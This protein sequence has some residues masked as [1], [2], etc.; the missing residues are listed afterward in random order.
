M[1]VVTVAVVMA[2]M[3]ALSGAALAQ[4]VAGAAD[5]KCLDLARQTLGGFGPNFNPANYT[6]VGGTEGNDNFTGEG[7]EGRDV[8]CGFGGDDFIE[9]LDEG[10]VF[11]G[12]AGNNEVRNNYGTFYGGEGRDAVH[13]HNYGTFYG[14]AGDDMVAYNHGTFYGGEGDDGVLVANFGTFVQ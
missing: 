2:A 11:L 4:P 3:M 9:T 8:F 1:L 5:A 14:G 7:T 13:G 10:D 6:F 12:G